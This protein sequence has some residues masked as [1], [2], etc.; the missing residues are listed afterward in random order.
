M[1]V[2]FSCTVCVAEPNCTVAVGG[3]Q[4]AGVRESSDTVSTRQPA[5]TG[6]V[7]ESVPSR[8]L[9]CT[10]WPSALAGRLTTV[11]VKPLELPVQTCRPASGLLLKAGTT[12]WL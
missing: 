1:A 8:H 10:L 11:V 12:N 5:P 7:E 4:Q 6:V 9:N 2:L 3:M